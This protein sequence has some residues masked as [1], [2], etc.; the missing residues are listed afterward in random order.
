MGLDKNR[1]AA[2]SAPN[3]ATLMNIANDSQ[4]IRSRKE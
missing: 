2:I 4:G 3:K 1:G